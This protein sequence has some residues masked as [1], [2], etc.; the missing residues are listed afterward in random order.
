VTF[1]PNAASTPAGIDKLMGYTT[2]RR[3]I[4]VESG[5]LARIRACTLFEYVIPAEAFELEDA[6]AGYYISRHTV[7]PSHKRAICDV[8]DELAQRNVELRLTPSLWPLR[9]AVADSTLEFSIS[10]MRNAQPPINGYV[11]KYPVS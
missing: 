3:V 2:A 8:M 6:H 9:D 1:A 7:I 4:V 5:W 11:P 10:R